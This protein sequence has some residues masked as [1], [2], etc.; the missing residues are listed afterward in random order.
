MLSSLLAYFKNVS[1]GTSFIQ[2]FTNL[3]QHFEAA[4]V[5]D[6]NA[7]NA[8]IDDLCQSLQALKVTAPAAPAAPVAPT[9]G[10]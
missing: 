8:L 5:V 2:A 7:R 4:Y 6:G 1:F 10:S 9:S 3:I